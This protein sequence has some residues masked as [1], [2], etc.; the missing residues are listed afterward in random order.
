MALSG[1]SEIMNLPYCK[2]LHIMLKDSVLF[3]LVLG[4]VLTSKN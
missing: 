3:N 2:E 1:H 4:C